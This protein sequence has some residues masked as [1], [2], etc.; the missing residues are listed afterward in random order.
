M[1]FN[2]IDDTDSIYDDFDNH[3]K[4]RNFLEERGI[5]D[6]FINNFN[7]SSKEWRISH[8]SGYHKS[9]TLKE[10]LDNTL[11]IIYIYIAFDWYEINE[12]YDYWLNI[13]AE[14]KRVVYK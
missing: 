12:G 5:L 9:Y 7:N 11:K 6:N 13:H 1:N 4:F 10:F 3:D 14:W 2:D 8:W